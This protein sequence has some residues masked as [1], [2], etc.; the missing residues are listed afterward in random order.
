MPVRY[1]MFVYIQG[2]KGKCINFFEH[3]R[4]VSLTM[5]EIRLAESELGARLLLLFNLL[6]FRSVHV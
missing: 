2:K 1:L 3:S 6:G 5:E 4:N